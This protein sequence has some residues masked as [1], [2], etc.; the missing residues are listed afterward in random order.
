MAVSRIGV[1]IQSRYHSTRLPGKALLPIGE[2][3][4][5]AHVIERALAIQGV[6]QVVLA[7]P[8]ADWE[9]YDLLADS[10][11]PQD[12][13]GWYLG[14]Q[15]TEDVLSRFLQAAIMFKIDHILRITGDCPLLCPRECERVLQ[16]YLAIPERNREAVF[17]TNDTAVSGTPDGMDCE[18]F[19]ASWLSKALDSSALTQA[20]REHV[21]P[22]IRRR[23]DEILVKAER[24]W[25][26]VKLSVDTEEDLALVR[27]VSQHLDEMLAGQALGETM[28]ALESLEHG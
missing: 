1:I 9:H 3:P 10:W 28:A 27:K 5:I 14:S 15:E 11:G 20:D 26:S 21:T 16:R 13:L 18:V 2:K 25:P 12:G 23:A 19:H 4:M 7:I 22:W 6:D 17:V 24:P 8:V